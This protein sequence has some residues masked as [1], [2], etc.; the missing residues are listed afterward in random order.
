VY[1]T[2]TKRLISPYMC[3]YT[4]MQAKQRFSHEH[5]KI[6]F[7]SYKKFGWCSKCLPSA[8]VNGVIHS[9]IQ[10]WSIAS[11]TAWC[12]TSHLTTIRCKSHQ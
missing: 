10:H 3:K 4:T 8:L 7:S 12:F 9:V 2:V 6:D 1:R 11:F 5:G